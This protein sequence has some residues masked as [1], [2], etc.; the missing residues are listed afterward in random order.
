MAQL[1]RPRRGSRWRSADLTATAASRPPA[2]GPPPRMANRQPVEPLHLEQPDRRGQVL[3][4]VTDA[5]APDER[6]EQRLWARWSNGASCSHAS[7]SAKSR[8][9]RA[10]RRAARG[11]PCGSGES[12]GAAPASQPSNSGL[13]SISSPSTSRRRTARKRSQPLRGSVRARLDRARHLDGVDEAVCEIERDRIA[14]VTTRAG[15]LSTITPSLLRHQRNSPRGSS[16][17]SHS[18]SQSRVRETAR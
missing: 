3:L 12:D 1:R 9:G 5:A 11:P 6:A 7:D 16:G 15:R 18:S 13:R 14:P 10:R 8:A 17:T 4:A 2:P